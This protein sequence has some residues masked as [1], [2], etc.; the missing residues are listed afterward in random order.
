[1][2]RRGHRGGGG[3]DEAREGREVLE[4]RSACYGE[5][6]AD[7]GVAGG[8]EIECCDKTALYFKVASN[9]QTAIYCGC[10]RVISFKRCCRRSANEDLVYCREF[11]GGGI[12]Y[13]QPAP[14]SRCSR[15][16]EV[17]PMSSVLVAGI[18]V[19]EN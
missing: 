4:V 5:I 19:R 1:M 3:R 12:L 13:E 6:A 11:G 2:E 10:S 8:D 7:G 16:R 9:K 18:I 17:V 15:L 14:I